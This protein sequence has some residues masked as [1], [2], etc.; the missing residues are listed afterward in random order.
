MTTESVPIDVADPIN[1]RILAVS[2]DRIAGFCRDPIGQIARQS[3]VEL[4]VVIE[5]IGAMLRAGT[6]RRVRQTLLATNLAQGSLVAWVVPQEGLNSAFDWMFQHDPFTGHVVIRSTDSAVAGSKYRL[7]TTLKVPQGYSMEK[8]CRHL[9]SQTGAEHFKLMPAKRLF[10]LG[11]GHVRRRGMEIGSKADAPADVIETG[12][13]ALSDRDWQVL[14]PLKREL[15]PEEITQN[16]W[17]DR[18]REAGVSLEEFCRV[19]EDLNRR[20][21]I[22]RFSTFLEHVKPL[23][24]GQRV[25]KFN[26]LFHWAVPA[27]REIETGCEVGRFHIMTHAYWRE[28]GPEFN[29]VN[30]MGVAHGTEKEMVLA[31]KRAMDEHLAAEKI[32]V[33]YTN[34]FWGGRSEIKPSEISPIEYENWCRAQGLDPGAMRG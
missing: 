16:L 6:I 24:D 13:V 21:V 27:G 9:C 15:A 25:T 34:V 10:A 17:A 30:I 18:A 22:G 2:E 33:S 5:R 14:I 12:I 1:A 20:G 28:G 31:H 7:W 26:A 32:P 23:A 29:N 4:P 8:H 19:A 11:V 3:G